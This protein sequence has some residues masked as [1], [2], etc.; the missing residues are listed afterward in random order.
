MGK[1]KKQAGKAAGVK[2]PRKIFS[3]NGR[4]LTGVDEIQ[5]DF[6]GAAA[7]LYVSGGE[8]FFG[9]PGAVAAYS[10]GAKAAPPKTVSISV[11][12]EGGVGKS[13]ITLRF[14]RQFF[15]DVWD[16]TIETAF[17]KMVELADGTRVNLE[18][19]DTAGQEDY[20]S[21]RPEWMREKDGYM[22]VYSMADS[23]SLDALKPYYELSREL[24]AASTY[25]GAAREVPI[26][27]VANKKDMCCE[28]DGGDPQLRKVSQVMGEQRARRWGARYMETSAK[29]AENIENAFITLVTDATKV[30]PVVEEE[31]KCPCIIL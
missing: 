2:H 12:G 24:N 19:L 6:S 23:F 25:G 1:L 27:L 7:Q 20:K 26:M 11:L 15:Q 4:E 3:E 30:E 21:L 31:D 17:T 28:E 5:L 18:I 29:T 22:F 13:A 8:P 10:P 9:G 14:V 16:P